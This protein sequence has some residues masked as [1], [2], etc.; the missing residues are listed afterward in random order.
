[1]KNIAFIGLGGTM[2]SPIAQNLAKA[3]FNVNGYNRTPDRPL[4]LQAAEAGVNVTPTIAEAVKD[5]NIVFICVSD[6]QDVKNVIFSEGGIAQN[7]KPNTLICDLSTIGTSAAREISGALTAQGFRFI[8]APVS[9]GDVGAKNGTLTIMVGGTKSDFEEALPVFQTIGKKIVYCGAAGNGQAVKLCNQLLC[10]VTLMA[11]CESLE[12]AQELD[13]DPQ[14]MIDVCS[15]GAAASWQLANLGEKAAESDFKPGFMVK[16]IVKDLR[17][18]QESSKRL[19]LP[20]ILL[21]DSLFKEVLSLG[22]AEQGTQAMI[23]A[24]HQS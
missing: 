3:G 15:S 18:V 19:N 8:D 24:Y 23:R 4:V 20:G 22:G 17:L 14:L 12:L 10:A 2:G 11:V 16:H 7:A 1:M 6:V 13:L 9:G 5:A 21:A